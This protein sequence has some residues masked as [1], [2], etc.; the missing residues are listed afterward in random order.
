MLYPIKIRFLAILTGFLLS[1]A[2]LAAPIGQPAIPDAFP[3]GQKLYDR[4][5]NSVMYYYG[6]TGTDPFSE[7]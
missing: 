6:I 4:Y 5:P 7:Y 2:V 1:S 3:Q